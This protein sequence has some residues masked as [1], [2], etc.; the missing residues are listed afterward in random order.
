[1]NVL[2][3]VDVNVTNNVEN[4]VPVV[5][6]NAPP[7]APVK[8]IVEITANGIPGTP[9]DVYTVSTGKTLII[10]DVIISSS[11]WGGLEDPCCVSIRRNGVGISNVSLGDGT[12]QHTYKTGIEFREGDI[13]GVAQQLGDAVAFFELRGFLMDN[14]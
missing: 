3:N 13:V 5:V 11:I 14:N 10:T 1:M 7:S 9:V 8:E 12:Y 4:P 2:N 6:Q